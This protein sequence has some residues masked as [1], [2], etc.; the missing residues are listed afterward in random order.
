MI[1]PER[2]NDMRRS[3]SSLL[4]IV[5]KKLWAPFLHRDGRLRRERISGRSGGSM[6]AA[7]PPIIAQIVRAP[8]RLGS[9][10]WRVRLLLQPLCNEGLDVLEINRMRKAIALPRRVAK[11]IR[12]VTSTCIPEPLGRSSW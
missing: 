7:K 6:P 8:A 2:P 9:R 3:N 10:R 12:L 1:V 4:T 11:R 5:L